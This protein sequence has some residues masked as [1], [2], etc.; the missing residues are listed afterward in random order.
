GR[1]TASHYAMPLSDD[2]HSLAD[3]VLNQVD[4]VR[5][6]YVHTCQARRFVQQ[7]ARKGRPVGIVNPTEARKATVRRFGRSDRST[8]LPRADL[9]PRR[10]GGDGA[11]R[12]SVRVRPWSRFWARILGD[13]E[14]RPGRTTTSVGRDVAGGQI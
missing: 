13:V 5:E 11:Q 8:I 3:Q 2:I 10:A 6:F 4:E 1:L 7:V 14:P 9:T 12:G